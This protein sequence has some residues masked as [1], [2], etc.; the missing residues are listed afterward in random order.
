MSTELST[1]ERMQKIQEIAERNAIE[2]L[3][4]L[5]R[6]IGGMQLC[7]AF[8][9]I[10]KLWEGDLLDLLLHMADNPLGFR[11]DAKEKPY[12]PIVIKRAAIECAL[13]G[14][15]IFG[16]EFN[17]I[18]GKCYMTKEFFERKVRELVSEL[19]VIEHVP[20]Q[21]QNAALVPMEATWIYAGKPDSIRC[22]K[23]EHGDLR[24]WV[25]VNAGMGVDAILG[26]A[27]RKLYARIYR[28]VTG[29]AWIEAEASQEPAEPAEPAEPEEVSGDEES[30]QY[31]PDLFVGIED[32]LAECRTLTDV[33]AFEAAMAEKLG[34]DQE[35]AA[36]LHEWCDDRRDKIRS[37][38]GQRSN[39]NG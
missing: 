9:Q 8:A 22:L 13:R 31:V 33:A 39:W 19:R 3:A 25:R 30:G 18:A 4:S 37:Q 12:P 23:T 5:P 10:E 35:A 29:S 24:I 11:T 28:R 6:F 17:V 38:R 26:K 14:G 34:D 21:A 20:Q 2:K 15:S 36:R 27:Y 7:A 1:R 32:Q 16:N